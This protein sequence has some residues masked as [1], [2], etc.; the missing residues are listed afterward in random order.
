MRA[1]KIIPL[2]I[3]NNGKL[4]AEKILVNIEI[5]FSFSKA[6]PM[7]SSPMKI[8]PKPHKMLP[9]VFTLSFLIK[10]SI[11]PIKANAEA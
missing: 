10:V 9:T 11:T 8:K 5:I 7:T 2:K 4:M 3:S 1:V 6:F